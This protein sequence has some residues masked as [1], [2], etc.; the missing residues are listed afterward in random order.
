VG[1]R[2]IGVQQTATT[3]EFHNTTQLADLRDGASTRSSSLYSSD[4]ADAGVGGSG[5]ERQ[6]VGRIVRKWSVVLIVE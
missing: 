5:S 6:V 2:R 1:H 4:I 3:S